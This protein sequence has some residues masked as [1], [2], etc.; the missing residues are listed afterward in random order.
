[1]TKY[2]DET[3]PWLRGVRGEE[4]EG[5]RGHCGS[6]VGEGFTEAVTRHCG[7]G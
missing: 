6:G 1:M 7:S 3:Q 2:R 5:D 4:R